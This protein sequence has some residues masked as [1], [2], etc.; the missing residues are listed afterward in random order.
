MHDRTERVLVVLIEEEEVQHNVDSAEHPKQDKVKW[1]RC[2]ELAIVQVHFTS[3]DHRRQW[4]T[5][6]RQT[7]RLRRPT[8]LPRHDIRRFG[9]SSGSG[10]LASSRA[11]RDRYRSPESKSRE[12]RATAERRVGRAFIQ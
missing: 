3:R 10:G 9:C 6:R 1:Q 12:N 8:W 11:R 7:R 2:E 5:A 4:W